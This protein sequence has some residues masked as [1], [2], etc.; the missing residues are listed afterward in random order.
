MKGI[1]TPRNDGS[2]VRNCDNSGPLSCKRWV[3][4]GAVGMLGRSLIKQIRCQLLSKLWLQDPA[5]YHEP[6]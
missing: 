1:V 6:T 5:I 4:V 2:M 3:P